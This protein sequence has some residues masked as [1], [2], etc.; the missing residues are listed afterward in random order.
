MLKPSP[1]HLPPRA[2]PSRM[3]SLNFQ[4]YRPWMRRKTETEVTLQVKL[5]MFIAAQPVKQTVL[6][7]FICFMVRGL[8]C[9]LPKMGTTNK[10]DYHRKKNILW[11]KMAKFSAFTRR[12]GPCEDYV[13]VRCTRKTALILGGPAMY[14][15]LLRK[16]KKPS[17]PKCDT[18]TC[19]ISMSWNALPVEEAA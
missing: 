2:E 8:V 12:R 6:T 13:E 15:G 1:Y 17:Q 5:Y 19:R 14:H 10:N 18:A 7:H 16:K 9:Q 11:S 3:I 4:C